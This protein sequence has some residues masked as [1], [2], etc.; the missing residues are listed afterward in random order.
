[1]FFPGGEDPLFS[2]LFLY[3]VECVPLVNTRI[4]FHPDVGVKVPPR[5]QI[6]IVGSNLCSNLTLV[7][8][9]P[10]FNNPYQGVS[11]N[12]LS[13]FLNGK[14]SHDS[15]QPTRSMSTTSAWGL[16]TPTTRTPTRCSWPPSSA[17]GP[18]R[19]SPGTAGTCCCR[20]FKEPRKQ[21]L[22]LFFY[23]PHR[24]LS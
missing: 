16:S 20:S 15:R 1:V 23:G 4:K 13:P 8:L 6:S 7:S 18:T 19:P 21:G 10:F 24:P 2:A 3:T 9:K 22:L 14:F 17:S 11:A 5:G 12:Q